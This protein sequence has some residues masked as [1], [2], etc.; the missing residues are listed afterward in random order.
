MFASPSLVGA[1]ALAIALAGQVGAFTT[2]SWDDAR[3]LAK[4]VVA[5]MTVD[6]MA[7][8]VSGRGQFGGRCVGNIHG[9][10]RLNIPDICFQD[11]PAGIRA[12][13]LA[14]GFPAGINAAATFNRDLM[15][16]RGQA[17]GEE[18]RAKG[19][20]VYLGP[21]IDIMRAPAAGRAWEGFGPDAYLTGEA[22]YETIMG[23]QSVGVQAVAKHLTAYVQEHYRFW[24]SS[25]VDD[26]TLHELYW[27]P[28]LRAIEADVSGIMCSYNK[29]NGTYACANPRLMNE[30]ARGEAGFAG[31]FVSDWLAT[32][33]AT[34]ETAMAGLD[35]EMPGG[36]LIF[37]GGTYDDIGPEAKNNATLLAR[38]REMCENII[39]PWY[40]LGQDQDFPALSFNVQGS[41]DNAHVNARSDAHT[42]LI[43]TIAAAS[44]VVVKNTGGLPLSSPASLAIIGQDAAPPQTGCDLNACL[45]GT[46]AIGWGSGTTTL[47][48]V[49]PPITALQQ[50]IGAQGNKTVLAQSLSNDI[51]PGVSAARGKS[52][53]IVFCVA[54]SGEGGIGLTQVD[55]NWGD[56][57]NLDLWRRCG[58]LIEA[59][60]KVNNN[61]IVVIHTV[62]PVNVNPWVSFANVT[63]IVFAGLPGEQTGPAIFDVLFGDVNPSGR[64]PYTI[65]KSEADFP[66]KVLLSAG[67]DFAPHVEFT[68]RYYNDYKH[69][70]AANIEPAFPFG[71]GLSYTTFSY[72]NLTVTRGVNPTT[73]YTVKF[74]VT[75]TGSRDGT[76]IPQLYLGFPSGSDEPPKLLRGFESVALAAGETKSV[77]MTIG[78]QQLSIWDVTSQSWVRP[79]GTF[80]VSVGASSRDIRLT[81]SF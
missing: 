72:A 34:Y 30:I 60:S 31:Y 46:L 52:A 1:C 62:G 6:E 18:F 25:D 45:G 57:E 51:D 12:V 27:A 71:H 16:K 58:S 37:G 61:T 81:G 59:V 50:R 39:T 48:Y 79:P 21:D 78:Q 38:L 41:S 15:R 23:V 33:D 4:T 9:V 73:L 17:I 2:R 28:Y 7:G 54:D 47:D 3:A 77:S 65:A 35:L 8:V 74:A 43:R 55:G 14:S 49:V 66:A 20:H 67:L 10:P 26:R 40:K 69:F 53:A 13:D 22:G 36:W 56:R 68:E 19:A 75:N 24:M 29:I 63:A 76:E 64:L 5:N 11:G 42:A 80:S 70:D 44:T 32:H